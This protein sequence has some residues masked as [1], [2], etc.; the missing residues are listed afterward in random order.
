[1]KKQYLQLSTNP[2]DNC[3]GPVVSGWVAVRE[4]E[5]SKESEIRQVGTICLS[6]GHGQSKND[7]AWY[8]PSLSTGRIGISN[9]RPVASCDAFE[10]MLSSAT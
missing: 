3:K 4:S 6:C 9:P 1:M 10:E 2:S 8:Y 7:G 5:I